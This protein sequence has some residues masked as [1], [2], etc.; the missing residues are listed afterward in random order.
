VTNNIP[1][2]SMDVTILIPDSSDTKIA[3]CVKSI[4]E[5]ADILV[6][7]NAPTAD[8]L[9]VVSQLKVRTCT[10]PEK[11]LAS[12]LNNGIANARHEQII[13]IDSDC[14]FAP[15]CISKLYESLDESLMARGTQIFLEDGLMT[16]IVGEAREYHAN[17]LPSETDVIRAYKPL[18]FRKEVVQM[19][20]GNMYFPPLKLSEDFEMDMRRQKQKIPLTYVKDAVVYHAPLKP[21]SDLKSA[22]K[23]GLDRHTVVSNG[24]SKPKKP[25]VQSMLKLK[26]EG[27]NRIG[28]GPSLYMVA[29]TIAYDLGYYSQKY[30][31]INRVHT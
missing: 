16:R 5:S 3:D 6:C 22:F 13:I 11:G 2:E 12:A 10:L 15:G 7:L 21:L 26:E 30:F 28:I 14:V 24:L 17:T 25:F 4:D 31:D 18:A 1:G 23:Y 29:W 9:E 20:G 19:L 8:V 27:L